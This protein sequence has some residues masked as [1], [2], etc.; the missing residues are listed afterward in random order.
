MRM[1]ASWVVLAIAAATAG[2]HKS[3]ESEAQEAVKA[4][5]AA[6]AKSEHAQRELERN[7]G[8]A[9][10]ALDESREA[11][12][13]AAREHA[14]VAEAVAREQAKMRALLTKEL[15]WIDKRIGEMARD[16]ASAPAG[17]V[18][19]EKQRDVDA[20]KAW[21]DRLQADLDAVSNPAPGTD[22]TQ[23]KTRIERDLDENRPPSVPRSYEKQY[24]I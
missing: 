18:K 6:A 5:A 9:A 4:S 8:E 13:K 21:R 12:E 15:G 22:W 7:A 17:K 24:G 20:A 16:A 1:R 23:L 3:S 11:T 2:C 19:D 14:D 10:E